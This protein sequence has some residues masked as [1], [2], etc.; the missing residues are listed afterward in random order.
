[1]RGDNTAA[2]EA[3]CVPVVEFLRRGP[4][5]LTEVRAWGRAY[6]PD[7]K[8]GGAPFGANLAEECL[9]WL[10]VRGRVVRGDDRR[11]RLV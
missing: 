9:Y 3:R 5:T 11:W 10:E 1:M 7:G 8:H 2:W 6:R 4:A